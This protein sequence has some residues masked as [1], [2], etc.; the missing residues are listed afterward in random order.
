MNAS[1][2]VLSLAA[3]EPGH[4][5]QALNNDQKMRE[6]PDAAGTTLSRLGDQSGDYGR[7]VSDGVERLRQRVDPL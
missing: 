3:P 6:R 7:F 4:R 2:R 5:Y 1:G